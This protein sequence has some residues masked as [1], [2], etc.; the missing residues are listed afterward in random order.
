MKVLAIDDDK[1]RYSY[2]ERL[3]ARKSMQIDFNVACCPIHVNAQI[4]QADV[5]FLD[6]DL[7]GYCPYHNGLKGESYLDEIIKHK[8]PTIVTSM[9]TRG[10]VLLYTRLREADIEVALIRASEVE[11]E[12]KWLGWI[13]LNLV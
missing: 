5:I 9:N 1:E 2:F 7:D 11:P 3:I 6:Y 12:L 10:G 8:K 13:F 4:E